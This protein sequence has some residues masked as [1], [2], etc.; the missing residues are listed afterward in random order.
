MERVFRFGAIVT[1]VALTV[2]SL[3][4][5]PYR[6]ETGASGNVEHAL[7]YFGSALITRLA[8][9]AVQSWLQLTAFSCVALCFEL[10]QVGIAGRHPGVDNWAASSAGALLGFVAAQGVL[11]SLRSFQGARRS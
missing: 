5:G 9:P 2:L 7:A 6:P 11:T 3:V 10:A 8:F 4:P 1:W